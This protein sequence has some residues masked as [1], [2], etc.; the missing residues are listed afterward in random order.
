MLVF[1]LLLLKD[2]A[3]FKLSMMCCL[4]KQNKVLKDMSKINPPGIAQLK[5][6]LGGMEQE[7]IHKQAETLEEGQDA[8]HNKKIKIRLVKT[9]P[10]VF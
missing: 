3:F 2:K 7:L 4:Y 5:H 8:K 9:E 1:G 6:L 10:T